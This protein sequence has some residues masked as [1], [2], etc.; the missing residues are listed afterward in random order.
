MTRRHT[1]SSSIALFAV[2]LLLAPAAGAGIHTWDVKEVFTNSDGTIQFVELLDVGTGGTET[3]VGN[4]SLTST[5]HPTGFSF[6][7]GPVAPPTNGKRYLIAT[8]DFAALPGAPT[9]DVIIPANRTPFFSTTGTTTISFSGVDSLVFSNPP[10]NGID[11]FD[12]N[13]GVGPNS[14]TNYAG[15]SGS[16]DASDPPPPGVPAWSAPAAVL[17]ASLL[18]LAAIARTRRRERTR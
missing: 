12:E 17:T 3:G 11:S 4:G 1:C 16:V 8:A 14:P 18:G 13:A 9:P 6:G 5:L 2:A 7:Q 10:T 15:Q